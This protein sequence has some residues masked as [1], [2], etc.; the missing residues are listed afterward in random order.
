M[1]NR[2][3]G[4]CPKCKQRVE[5]G[6]GTAQRRPGGAWVVTHNE[7]KAKREVT[8]YTVECKR[9][10][11][12]VYEWMIQPSGVLAGQELKHYLATFETQEEALTVY[13]QA[14][15]SNK[16]MEPGV[17]LNHLPGEDDPVPGGMF[18]DDIGD[19]NCTGSYP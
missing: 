11:F 10:G 15:P 12:V 8:R 18:P 7:C 17:Y 16:W 9:D 4:K 2:Y 3:P 19:E 13:P 14:K 5:A 6:A 1:I